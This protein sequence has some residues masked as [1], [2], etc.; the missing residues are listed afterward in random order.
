M[1]RFNTGPRTLVI[2]G[3]T[4]LSYAF[5]GGIVTLSGAGA[6]T[7]TVASP[8]SFPGT[9]QVFYN[10]SSAAVTLATPVGQLRGPGFTGGAFQTIEAGASMTIV[11]DGSNYI[12]VNTEG[13]IVVGTTATFTGTLT[14]PTQ[15]GSTSS[16]GTLIM[17]GTSHATKAAASILM[18]DNV[19]STST[20]T[21]TLVITGGVG[22]SENLYVGGSAVRFTANSASTGTSSGTLVVTGGVGVG[23]RINAADFTG[24]VGANSAN[25]GA[26]TTLSANNTVS[27]TANQSATNTASGTLRVTGGASC[28]ENLWVGGYIDAASMQDTPIGT[29]TRSSAAFTTL[30]ANN[31]V[32]LTQ[33]ASSSNTASG[34]LVVTGGVGISENLFVGGASVRFTGNTGSSNTSSGTLVV[35]GGVGISQN[36]YVGSSLVAGSIS[37]TS[38][39]TLKRDITPIENALDKILNLTGVTYFRTADDTFEAGLIAEHVNKIIPELVGRDSKGNPQTV[40][41]TKITAY[42]IEAVKSLKHEL[43][44]IK[45]KN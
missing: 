30:T 40:Y 44:S 9:T 1:A 37:E 13:N 6:Y 18:D 42:L 4:I 17:R 38:S 31:S 45:G 8:V 7:V 24:T 3:T 11:S 12:I 25:T 29:V 27:L 14:A 28:T 26:F 41:Y 39:E 2:S 5:T 21:G 16:S 36:C 20:T 15:N 33:N 34:T 23:G 10:G 43:D 22:L 19:T 32:T 35:T